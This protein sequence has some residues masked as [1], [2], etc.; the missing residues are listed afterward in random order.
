MITRWQAAA[1]Q[2]MNR[3]MLFDNTKRQMLGLVSADDI[4]FKDILSK[5]SNRF[6]KSRRTRLTFKRLLTLYGSGVFLSQI[7]KKDG[8][9]FP[10]P[11]YREI[12]TIKMKD[13]K[14]KSKGKCRCIF[15]RKIVTRTGI[16]SKIKQKAVP[17]E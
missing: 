10:N 5:S 4:Y 13:E 6:S 11:T 3:R 2:F 7:T 16:F 15:L 14:R 8:R 9:S 12:Y 17:H 1:A